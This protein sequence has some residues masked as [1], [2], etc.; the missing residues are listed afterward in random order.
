MPKKTLTNVLLRKAQPEAKEYSWTD[1]SGLVFRVLPSGAK[2]FCWRCKDLMRGLKQ[3]RIIYGYYPDLSL[4]DAKSIH[5]LFS[6][7]R[8]N[9]A[10]IQSPEILNDIIK[11]VRS[12]QRTVT[13]HSGMTFAE[14]V[15]YYFS[16]YVDKEVKNPAPYR[17]I[18]NHLQPIL[19]DYYVSKIN[20]QIIGDTI[21]ALKEA[22]CTE[23]TLVDTFDYAAMMFE[24]ALSRGWVKNNPFEKNPFNRKRRKRSTFYSVQEIRTLLTNPLNI[25]I[26]QD[27]LMILKLLFLT[28]CR[29]NEVIKAT[30]SE[31]I[32]GNGENGNPGR[33]SIIS[34]RVK[35]MEDNGELETFDIP[36]SRQ[37][38][39]LFSEAIEKYGNSTHV[40]GSKK[41]ANTIATF[42][43]PDSGALCDR[44]ADRMMKAYRERYGIAGKCTHDMRRTLETTLGNLFYPDDVVSLMTGHIR[45]G[46]SGV[47]NQSQKIWLIRR[48]FQSWSDFVEFICTHDEQYAISFDECLEDEY[49]RELI[50][51]FGYGAIMA[52][53]HKYT[54]EPAFAQTASP[55]SI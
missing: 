37:M 44:N 18:K 34:D 15:T 28:G 3:T 41:F 39:E 42:G 31:V 6:S 21:E 29:R 27:Y 54:I 24:F 5:Y 1:P 49:A 36:M 13:G 32:F 9:G 55:M 48:C 30:L 19:A 26:G 10:D 47:Y 22:K 20:E 12:K 38:A 4:A 8:S 16:E 25:P 2:V 52:D 35:N 50:A 7:A 40:F 53:M 17:R 45:R 14:L 43:K 51:R 46:I 23:R 11:Q 33:F